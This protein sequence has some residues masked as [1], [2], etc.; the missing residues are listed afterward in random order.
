MSLRPR[1]CVFCFFVCTVL[2]CVRLCSA[3]AAV[4]AAAVAVASASTPHIRLVCN[5]AR[6]SSNRRRVSVA[7]AVLAQKHFAIICRLA[8]P[9]VSHVRIFVAT[10]Y[11]VCGCVLLSPESL[12]NIL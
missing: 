10:P 4:A 9:C 11:M 6:R 7:R 3:T 5:V 8:R 1:V 12:C 2:A